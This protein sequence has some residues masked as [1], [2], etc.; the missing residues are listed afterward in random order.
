[1]TV[2][3]DE[4]LEGKNDEYYLLLPDLKYNEADERR[5]ESWGYKNIEDVMW[6]VPSNRRIAVNE[7]YYM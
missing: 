6:L 2:F 5:Y 3:S 7:K 1:M 4:I